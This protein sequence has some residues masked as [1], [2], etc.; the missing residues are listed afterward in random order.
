MATAR[1]TSG[2]LYSYRSRTQNSKSPARAD[3]LIHRLSWAGNRKRPAQPVN[4][5]GEPIQGGFGVP[6]GWLPDGLRVASGWL[7]PELLHSSFFISS[8][9]RQ[10][11]PDL[12]PPHRH[13]TRTGLMVYR[14]ERAVGDT[15]PPPNSPAPSTATEAARVRLG[16]G[17][18]VLHYCALFCCISCRWGASLRDFSSWAA[19]LHSHQSVAGG[20]FR[21]ATPQRT[22]R[23]PSHS[24]THNSWP[25]R[26][27]TSTPPSGPRA[28]NCA[29]GFR[30]P[31]SALRIEARHLQPPRSEEHTSE[32][33]S[34]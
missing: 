14:Y 7:R 2:W 12:G 29:A 18:A 9:H 28:M 31:H 17:A 5:P 13:F 10:S 23:Q 15:V 33:Q 24:G 19:H 26:N 22:L 6:T 21:A 32:L 16:R 1:R 25:S 11:V 20:P 30:A 3:G 8:R 34:P 27:P 4:K